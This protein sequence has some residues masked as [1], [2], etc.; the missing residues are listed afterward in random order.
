MCKK[1]AETPRERPG[2]SSPLTG[3]GRESS[4]SEV[5]PTSTPPTRADGQP[6]TLLHD[7]YAASTASTR[8]IVAPSWSAPVACPPQ[9]RRSMDRSGD[10]ALAGKGETDDQRVSTSRSAISQSGVAPLSRL[11]RAF[12]GQAPPQSIEPDSRFTPNKEESVG[13]RFTKSSLPLFFPLRRLVGPRGGVD[14]LMR[15]FEKSA[16]AVRSVRSYRSR[17]WDGPMMLE[18]PNVG[19]V[20]ILSPIEKR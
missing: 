17:G 18:G 2:H 7:A 16:K 9:P 1:S 13:K 5:A 12:G 14:L 20:S 3:A 15:W 4:F 8:G 11:R 10:G 6:A 19:L